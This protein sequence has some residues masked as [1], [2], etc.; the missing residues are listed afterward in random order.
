MAQHSAAEKKQSEGPL[1]LAVSWLLIALP[2]IMLVLRI[3]CKTVLSRGLG[4]D[5]LVIVLSWVRDPIL[6]RRSPLAYD[7][8]IEAR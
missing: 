5:D 8:L 4:W 2:G 3:F 6:T 7:V 1:I